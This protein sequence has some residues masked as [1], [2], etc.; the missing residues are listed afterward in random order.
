MGEGGGSGNAANLM[1]HR[2]IVKKPRLLKSYKSK[3]S[4]VMVVP[5]YQIFMPSYYFF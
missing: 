5:L 4:M 3:Y 2:Y 1:K